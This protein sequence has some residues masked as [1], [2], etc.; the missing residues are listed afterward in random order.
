MKRRSM[1]GSRGG[2]YAIFYGALLTVAAI[3]TLS[4]FFSIVAYKSGNP[5]ARLG[6]FSLITLTVSGFIG[7]AVTS[8][9]KGAGGIGYAL[10]LAA[11]FALLLL[12][13]RL[14]FSFVDASA[15]I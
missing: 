4:L 8:R 14:I 15:L 3:L 7:G 6:L 5:T 11:G 13:T 1:N 12:S 2:A 9:I 10:A